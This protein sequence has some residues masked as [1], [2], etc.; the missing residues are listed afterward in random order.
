MEGDGMRLGKH[1]LQSVNK[2]LFE[3]ARKQKSSSAPVELPLPDFW[4]SVNQLTTHLEAQ[5]QET[6]RDEGMSAKAQL[7]TRQLGNVRTVVTD[8]TRIR[9]NAFTQHAILTNLMKGGGGDAAAAVQ[10]L[11]VIDW[12]RHDA[13]ERAYYQSLSH[14]VEKYKHDVSWRTLVNGNNGNGKNIIPQPGPHEPLTAFTSQQND[15]ENPLTLEKTQ[16]APLSEEIETSWDS[17]NFDEEDRIREMDAFPNRATGEEPVPP[18][19]VTASEAIGRD[20][21]RIR[22]LQDLSDPIIAE[23]GSEITLVEGD[24]ESCP[25]LIAET[26]IAAGLAVAAPI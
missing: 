21:I 2:A 22:I 20:L 17:A 10:Q 14:L 5:L 23:D 9:L 18:I 8:L 16:T 25:S 1:Q 3:V 6:I 13:S 4:D 15:S 7:L 12:E 19:Q 11:S 26:L 24:V